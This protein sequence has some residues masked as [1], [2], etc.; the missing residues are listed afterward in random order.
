VLKAVVAYQPKRMAYG[1]DKTRRLLVKQDFDAVFKNALRLTNSEFTV[2]FSRNQLTHSRLGLVLSKKMINKSHDR[3][4]IKRILR[5]S[6]RLNSQLPAVDV[7]VL[8][9]PAVNKALP[10]QIRANLDK[11]WTE[12][13]VQ[14]AS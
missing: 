11:L 12:L 7:V 6:F 8:A 13:S 5:E 10:H 4:R 2:L 9:R 14:H 1:F 3:N